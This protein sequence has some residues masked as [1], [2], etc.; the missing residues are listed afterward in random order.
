MNNIFMK[1]KTRRQQCEEGWGGAGWVE[2]AGQRGASVVLSTIKISDKKGSVSTCCYKLLWG[3]KC[4][5]WGLNLIWKQILYDAAGTSVG[6]NDTAMTKSPNLLKSNKN[7]VCALILTF[8]FTKVTVGVQPQPES[9]PGVEG[10][11]VLEAGPDTVAQSPCAC[12]CLRG[13][14]SG[15]ILCW[16]RRIWGCGVVH[17]DFPPHAKWQ[18]AGRGVWQEGQAGSLTCG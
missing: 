13:C 6:L 17:M 12:G 5:T 3:V 15:Q 9:K 4:L 18:R 14:G 11:I 16:S 7:S 8:P 2:G 1:S 10:D